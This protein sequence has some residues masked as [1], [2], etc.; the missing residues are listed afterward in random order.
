MPEEIVK[1]ILSS[2]P[3]KSVSQGIA[4]MLVAALDPKLKGMPY[5][6]RWRDSYDTILTNF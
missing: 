4:T 2:L 6:H 5:I 3:V 1:A